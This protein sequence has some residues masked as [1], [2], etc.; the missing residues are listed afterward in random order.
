MLVTRRDPR[1][2]ER[3][4]LDLAATYFDEAK[5]HLA[6]DRHP[7]RL[8]FALL[9]ARHLAGLRVVDNVLEGVASER[10]FEC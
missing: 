4:D 2:V 10:I 8:E 9:V 3:V 5:K 6:E 7:C 1:W